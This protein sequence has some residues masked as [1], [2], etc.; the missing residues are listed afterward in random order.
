MSTEVNQRI[1]KNTLYLYI[2]TGFTLLVSLYTSRVVFNALGVE[3][4]GIWGVLGGLITMFSFI[5]QSLSSSIFRYI[6]HAIGS[7]NI[8][9][10]NN[11]YSISIII[12]I[13]L[14]LLIFFLCETLGE[15]VLVEKM[16]I[17]IEK[18]EMAEIVFH[19]VVVSSSLSL[20]SVP[21]NS[22]IIAY[23][24]MNV[25][26]YMAIVDVILK[27]IIAFI[28]CQ[29]STNRLIWYSLMMLFITVF[30]LI[31]YVLYVIRNFKE[32]K[33]KWVYD[34]DLYKS[35]LSFSG[36]SFCGN[37]ATV[38]YNQGL[39][40]LLNIFFGPVVNAA[41][42][43]SLQIE[44]TVRT[45]VVN[46]QSAINPQIIKNY[47]QK[48]FEQMHILMFRSS[49][50]SVFLLFIFALPIM[51]ETDTILYLWLGQVQHNTVIF[52]RIMFP[53][54]ALETMSNSLMTGVV[55][56]G[57]IRNYQLIVSFILILIVPISYIVLKL[58]ADAEMV[59]IIYLIMEILAVIARLYFARKMVN[60]NIKLFVQ[61]VIIPSA[62][63]IL[64]GSLIPLTLHIFIKASYIHSICVIVI[65]GLTS[66]LSI[67][68]F[69]MTISE[70]M[71]VNQI[72]RKKLMR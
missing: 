43:I 27:F 60:L 71:L 39:N 57:H 50:F 35:I 5:N 38:G 45:F 31:V 17:S 13:L 2:R 51:L 55:A 61:Y 30:M 32:L 33:F 67:Y 25:Y 52:I 26:A 46:F 23:E 14:A 56:N 15:W 58:G 24:R 19:I 68:L 54:I 69:G 48:E 29:I 36:W 63:V 41:R 22:V 18:Q 8:N 70:R 1:A 44:Q 64:L 40:I 66:C 6:T 4:F 7:N 37:I 72:I 11:V 34:L 10:L 16:V 21:F 42:A 9:E 53:I 47:A 65:S 59:F 12:H 3:D 28:I 49:K 62:I 20:L